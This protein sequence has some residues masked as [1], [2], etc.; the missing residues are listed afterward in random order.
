M[1][2]FRAEGYIVDAWKLGL[3]RYTVFCSGF[4]G[5]CILCFGRMYAIHLLYMDSV[6]YCC[7]RSSSHSCSAVFDDVPKL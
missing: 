6:A 2:Q 4:K 3:K 1:T 7:F 5:D